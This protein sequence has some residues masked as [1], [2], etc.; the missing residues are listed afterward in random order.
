MVDHVDRQA[1]PS[2]IC[3]ALRTTEEVGGNGPFRN[4]FRTLLGLD[5]NRR[6]YLGIVGNFLADASNDRCGNPRDL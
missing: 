6:A 2:G 1:G 4:L 3:V 5:G